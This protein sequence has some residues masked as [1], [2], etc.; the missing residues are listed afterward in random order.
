MS[1]ETLA[2]SAAHVAEFD[3]ESGQLLLR[4]NAT[5]NVLC[6]LTREE[7]QRLRRMLNEVLPSPREQTGQEL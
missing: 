3:M 5:W 1:T 6:A 2:L 7:A 4:E